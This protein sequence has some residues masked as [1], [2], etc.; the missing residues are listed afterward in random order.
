MVSN[1]CLMRSTQTDLEMPRAL[2]PFHKLYY[3]GDD[4]L[5]LMAPGLEGNVVSAQTETTDLT[6]P[7][8]P[9]NWG[10]ETEGT[11]NFD[12]GSP[13]LQFTPGQTTAR[14]RAAV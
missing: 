12:S 13:C 11:N 6:L 5:R 1:P 3:N 8:V 2:N 10:L 9:S 7:L 14:H 4:R